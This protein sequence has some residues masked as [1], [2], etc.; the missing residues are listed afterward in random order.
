M[1]GDR[2]IVRCLDLHGWLASGELQNCKIPTATKKGQEDTGQR[3]ETRFSFCSSFYHVP[4]WLVHYRKTNSYKEVWKRGA[5][6]MRQD[7][8]LRSKSIRNVH[9]LILPPSASCLPNSEPAFKFQVKG[10][11][12]PWGTELKG[13]EEQ[14]GYINVPNKWA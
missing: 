6:V 5:P 7:C 11:L 4:A 14:A 2:C 8:I 9:A 13:L 12:P 10:H 3:W 1:R